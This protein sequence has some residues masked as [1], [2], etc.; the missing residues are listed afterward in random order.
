MQRVASKSGLPAL[1]GL[2]APHWGDHATSTITGKTYATAKAHH[3][4]DVFDAMAQDIGS[5]IAEL[6][7]DGGGS[8]S[9]VLMHQCF[10]GFCRMLC[11]SQ[12][13]GLMRVTKPVSDRKSAC[14]GLGL[15]IARGNA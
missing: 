8:A 5:Q 3:I 15:A 6:R 9:Y 7:A 11:N 13:T 12:L 2:G 10:V 14:A 4:A 1:A